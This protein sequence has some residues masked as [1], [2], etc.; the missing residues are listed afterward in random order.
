MVFAT[1]GGAV[2]LTE[3]S[4]STD[5]FATTTEGGAK[6]A[7]LTK[8]DRGIRGGWTGGGGIDFCLSQHWMLNFT[9]LYV[10][11]GDESVSSAAVLTL[12]A[13]FGVRTFDS[14]TRARAD[15]QFLCKLR[16]FRDAFF[17]ALPE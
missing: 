1:G 5:V 3:V 16:A 17:N 9:Y 10:D 7:F 2:G 13:R 8:S 14:A 12:P 11:L 15:F 6:T 4:E